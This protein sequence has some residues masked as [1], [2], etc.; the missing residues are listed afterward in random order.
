MS[1][2]ILDAKTSSPVYCHTPVTWK[3]LKNIEKSWKTIK[4]KLNRTFWYLNGYAPQE[5][6]GWDFREFRVGIRFFALQASYKIYKHPQKRTKQ[7]QNITF[8][9]EM[10]PVNPSMFW[11]RNQICGSCRLS[12]GS[13]D[14]GILTNCPTECTSVIPSQLWKLLSEV[15]FWIK[16]CF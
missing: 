8:T 16:C 7:Y 11:Y 1:S 10:S 13:V 3:S 9:T 14:L 6:F 2:M 5:R 15:Y 12:S 4:M